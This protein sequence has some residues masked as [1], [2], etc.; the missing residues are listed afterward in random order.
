MKNVAILA[1]LVTVCFGFVGCAMV[2]SPCGNGAIFSQFK[3]AQDLESGKLGSKCG[4]AELQNILGWILTGD[5]TIE[6]AAKNA[7]I[8]NVTHADYEGFSVLGIW[9]KYTIYVYGE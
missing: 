1:L 9:A 2:G 6:T 5:A 3:A 4:K 7:G 8:T